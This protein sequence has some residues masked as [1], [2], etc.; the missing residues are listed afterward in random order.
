MDSIFQRISHSAGADHWRLFRV[1]SAQYNRLT[2]LL[3]TLNCTIGAI[4]VESS[5]LMR[6]SVISDDRAVMGIIEPA[7]LSP[8]PFYLRPESFCI[9][10]TD[11]PEAASEYRDL[12]GW[13]PETSAKNPLE[14]VSLLWMVLQTEERMAWLDL[15]CQ[16]LRALQALGQPNIEGEPLFVNLGRNLR[17]LLSPDQIEFQ[18]ESPGDFWPGRPAGW[19]WVECGG[20]EPIRAFVTPRLQRLVYRRERVMFIE[21]LATASDIQIESATH[22]QQFRSCILLPLVCGAE[23]FGT[24][25]LFYRTPLTPLPGDV[26]A[27]E[28][29]RRELSVLMDRGRTHLL[30]QRMATVD[31]LTNLFNHRFFLD[32]ARTEFQRALRYQK[33]MALIMIDIDDFKHYNDTYGHLAGDRV[34]AETA[35][36][37]RGVVRD[38]DFVARYGGE[39]FAL[40]LPEVDAQNGLVVAEK[41]RASVESLRFISDDGEA[42]G[43]ITVSCGVTDNAEASAPEDMIKRADDALYWVKRHGRNLVQL[44]SGHHDD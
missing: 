31:G 18:M 41:I 26:E 22:E 34:L 27:L 3:N 37:I 36:T 14:P 8:S 16:V 30:M 24:L 6:T 13:I 12:L 28:L 39:E 33:R 19:T 20:R 44:A 5:L 43:S 4:P 17:D 11:D 23:P 32:Q 15:E 21:D 42:V 9:A 7:A 35:R 25:R 29:L 38:I 40:I 2:S 1:V 10:Y